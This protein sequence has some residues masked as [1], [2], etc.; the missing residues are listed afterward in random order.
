MS[1]PQ[2]IARLT[3][4][5]TS[6]HAQFPKRLVTFILVCFI[7][8][9]TWVVPAADLRLGIIGTDTSH[10]IA[11]TELLNNPAA[12][13][14]VPGARVVAAFKGG[15]P[16]IPASISRVETNANLLRDKYAVK[17]CDT[18]EELCSQ[19]DGVLLESVDGR[20]H[21]SQAKV[22]LAAG[23]PLFIDK[24]LAGDLS[25]ALEII[26]RAKEANVPMFTSSSLRYDKTT[27]AVRSGSIGKV[28][29]AET[30]SPANLEP[31]HPDLFWYGIHGC[32]SLFTVMGVGC[33]SVVRRTTA[34]GKIEVVGTWKG[35]RT[36]IFR[37]AKGYGGKAQGD[38]AESAVGAYDGYAPL[39]AEIIKFFQTGQSP[40]PT[41]ETIE[42]FAFMEAAD[43]SKRRGGLAVTLAEVLAKA[44]QAVPP[45]TR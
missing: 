12:K 1:Q 45:Q 43:E 40:V 26:R 25:A 35:G 17:I 5:T 2:P 8:I 41:E 13:N 16:D 22:V 20:T 4:P 23:K 7:A 11:F 34:D 44:H 42:L 19:V 10:A 38:K 6:C 32:E 29:R 30:T 14:H 15:S 27:Q 37:E 18:I 3:F 24:P 36:G 31:T 9:S 33:E 21:L 28:L 39:V